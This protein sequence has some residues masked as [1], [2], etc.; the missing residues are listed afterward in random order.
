MCVDITYA[1]YG[2]TIKFENEKLHTYKGWGYMDTT[3]IQHVKIQIKKIP[4]F[5]SQVKKKNQITKR[6]KGKMIFIFHRINQIKEYCRLQTDQF[7]QYLRK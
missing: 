3:H 4:K 2:Q 1:C 5:I 7:S 6:N